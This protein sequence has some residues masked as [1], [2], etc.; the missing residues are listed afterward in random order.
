V[1]APELGV[2]ARVVS[3]ADPAA[4]ATVLDRLAGSPDA[5]REARDLAWRLGRSRYNWDVEKAALLGSVER[6]FAGRRAAA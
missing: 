2:A 1:L 5:R 3:L 6:A 4:I